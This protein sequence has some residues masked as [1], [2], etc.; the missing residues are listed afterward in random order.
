[1]TANEFRTIFRQEMLAIGY[2][3][4]WSGGAGP[5]LQGYYYDG[6]VPDVRTHWSL[7]LTVRGK[8]AIATVTRTG[9]CQDGRDR[10]R[11]DSYLPPDDTL[12]WVRADSIVVGTYLTTGRFSLDG[13]PKKT[14]RDVILWLAATHNHIAER[15]T[16]TV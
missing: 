3:E 2:H 6:C 7:D 8:N 10:G 11:D 14:A 9:R 4:T 1:M 13:D 15:L 12:P 16:A 5:L